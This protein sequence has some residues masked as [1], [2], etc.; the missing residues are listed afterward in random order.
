MNTIRRWRTS[1]A[2]LAAMLLGAGAQLQAQ[3]DI[4]KSPSKP[5][6][7]ASQGY[8]FVAGQYFTAPDGQFMADQMYVEFQIPQNVKHPFPLVMIHGG[9][10]TG[11]NFMGT[12][13]GRK[14]WV[15]FFLE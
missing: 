6:V 8:F 14:G 7:I 2:A 4:F 10:Q 12:P 1:V 9:A 13:D 3:E 15:Q 5:L 11:T